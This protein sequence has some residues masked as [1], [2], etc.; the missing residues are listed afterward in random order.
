MWSLLLS[1]WTCFLGRSNAPHHYD[2]YY[3]LSL[4]SL[5][6]K[7]SMKNGV[8]LPGWGFLLSMAFL[9]A[10]LGWFGV[11]GAGPGPGAEPLGVTQALQAWARLAFPNPQLGNFWGDGSLV[12]WHHTQTSSAASPRKK[13]KNRSF[14][15]IVA[16]LTRL[17]ERLRKRKKIAELLYYSVG[18]KAIV[19][20]TT[21]IWE[22]GANLLMTFLLKHNEQAHC[23]KLLGSLAIGDSIFRVVISVVL[24]RW[25]GE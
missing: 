2:Y 8:S 16:V 15:A 21:C 9:K 25:A 5:V 4:R 11:C 3:K 22:R 14:F 18:L 6:N 20:S 13:T 10:W 17:L 23:I 1:P 12:W 19:S 7:N 24:Y